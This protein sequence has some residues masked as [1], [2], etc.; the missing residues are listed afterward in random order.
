MLSMYSLYYGNNSRISTNTAFLSLS[1]YTTVIYRPFT[2]HDKLFV[3]FRISWAY[4]YAADSHTLLCST[5]I[6]K[7]ESD[8][9][10][11]KLENRSSEDEV[12]MK[13]DF[14]KPLKKIQ[15]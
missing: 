5:I 7:Y 11:P 4:T 3:P 12:C 14:V 10:A 8:S 6:S 1:L 15:C 2:Q 13:R 9:S